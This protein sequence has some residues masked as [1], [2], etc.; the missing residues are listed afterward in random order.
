MMRLIYVSGPLTADTKGKTL[1][2]IEAAT[3]ATR[4][5]MDAGF[6]VICPHL[7]Y[8]L[9]T[10]NWN[11]SHDDWLRVDVEILRRCDAV[12]MLPGWL[13]SKG[14]CME[15]AHAITH[16]IPDVTSIEE[17]IDYPWRDV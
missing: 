11:P 9:L 6:A 4:E 14:A 1:G 10:P 7:S 17:L 8:Y 3:Q 16:N 2:N 13:H 15:R 5:L 12:L